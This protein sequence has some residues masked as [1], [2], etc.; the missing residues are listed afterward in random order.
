MLRGMH[1]NTRNDAD[2]FDARANMR[3]VHSHH[4]LLAKANPPPQFAHCSD[5]P[6]DLRVLFKVRFRLRQLVA[7]LGDPNIQCR[8]QENA[9]QQS[10]QEASNNHNGEGPLRV[11]PDS[12]RDGRGQQTESSHEGSHQDRAK[13]QNGPVNGSILYRVPARTQ[14]IDVLQHDYSGLDAYTKE[15]Q[16]TNA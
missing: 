15:R 1:T 13:P 2:L 4:S 14:L 16:K 11:R 5:S 12:P 3:S 7:V 8:Q 6:N 10:S 9:H